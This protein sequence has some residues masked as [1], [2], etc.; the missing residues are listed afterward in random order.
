MEKSNIFS[1]N[2]II[3]CIVC[4]KNLMDDIKMSM[5]QI[6]TDENNQ[7]IRVLPCCKGECDHILQDEIKDYEGNGFRDLSTFVNPYLY[8]KNLVQMM[9]R[10][11]EGKGFANQ[12]AFDTYSDLILN[13]YQYVS[14]NL[15]EEEKEVAK[16][17]TLLP[18]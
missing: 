7:I 18:L 6:I 2:E 12:Q 9:D 1:N 17:T 10:M 14:R 5:V 16:R 3:K 11:F 15:S 13:C 8:I 4:G